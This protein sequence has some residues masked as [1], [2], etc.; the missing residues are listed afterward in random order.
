MNEIFPTE[1]LNKA[2]KHLEKY[3]NFKNSILDNKFVQLA[4]DTSKI[5]GFLQ[6]SSELVIRKRF[7]SFLKGFKREEQPSIE[8]LNK[9]IAYVDNEAK[10]EFISDTFSKVLLAKSSKACVVMGSILS[11]IVEDKE[12]LS[13]IHLTCINA[14]M[15]F[16]DFDMGNYVLICK[17]FKDS[18][19]KKLHE[20]G[21]NGRI[22][23][24]RLN[25]ES[26]W[27]TID[28]AINYQM[29]VKD[30]EV[31]LSM[32]VDD[33]DFSTVD[34]SM[35]YCITRIGHIFFNYIT[36]CFEVAE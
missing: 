9:L 13:H 8:Q 30:I 3:L 29:L 17:F 32:F 6:R 1:F 33:I 21:I 27:I 2:V 5:V 28:K 7:E 11:S 19:V 4:G 15:N 14:L 24:N 16:N 23:R 12:N 26:V 18:K 31:D 20:S 34:K 25:S 10:A 36:R 35:T 22:G